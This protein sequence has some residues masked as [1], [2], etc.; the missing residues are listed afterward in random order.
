MWLYFD[1]FMISDVLRSNFWCSWC[2]EEKKKV[3]SCYSCWMC[4]PKIESTLETCVRKS[5]GRGGN[6]CWILLSLIKTRV[7]DPTRWRIRFLKQLLR[8]AVNLQNWPWHP[9]EVCCLHEFQNLFALLSHLSSVMYF[10]VKDSTYSRQHTAHRTPH[11]AHRT[12]HNAQH[13]HVHTTAVSD[14]P[15]GRFSAE[16]NFCVSLHKCWVLSVD[17]LNLHHC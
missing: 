10:R 2:T 17:G 14:P 6:L 15:M 8:T 9:R 5:A 7:R 11:T 3:I 4:A 12:P 1:D 16:V 13:T